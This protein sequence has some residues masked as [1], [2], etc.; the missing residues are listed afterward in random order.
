M[1]GATTTIDFQV[2]VQNTASDRLSV[3]FGGVDMTTLG[4]TTSNLAGATATASQ[5]ALGE[6]DGALQ[7]LSS[8]RADF[9]ATLNRMQVTVSNLQSMRTNLSA[10]HGRIVDVDVAEESAMMA[11]TQV[12]AQ[13]GVA[14]LAQANQTPQLALS[15]LKG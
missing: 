5:T 4:L 1:S 7:A 14:I 9:G 8:R 6:V 11:R 10:A 2:G 3:A 12:L 15:L 13:A